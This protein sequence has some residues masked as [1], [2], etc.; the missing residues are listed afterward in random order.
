M[1]MHTHI[2]A[3]YHGTSNRDYDVFQAWKKASNDN[4]SINDRNA[5]S[6]GATWQMLYLH[7][8]VSICEPSPEPH[9]PALAAL[10]GHLSLLGR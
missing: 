4:S 2:T 1:H 8:A 7:R 9:V 6:D 10:C 5:G 3:Q